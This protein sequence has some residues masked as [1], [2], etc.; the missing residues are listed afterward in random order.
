MISPY[1]QTPSASPTKI[2]DLPSTLESS[3][4]APRAALAALA[5][6]FTVCFTLL[7][8]VLTP[9]F[10]GY[11]WDAALAYFFT[12]FLAML[13]QT[14]CA[15][16]SVALLFPVLARILGGVRKTTPANVGRMHQDMV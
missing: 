5:A 2:S 4:M 1:R 14:V 13:P 15:A 10:Y 8:D 12:G 7:D 6:F 9:L 16:V 11:T 3:L